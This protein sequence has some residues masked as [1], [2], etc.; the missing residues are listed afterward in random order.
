M[1]LLWEETNRGLNNAWCGLV[2]VL[3]R[4]QKRPPRQQF[5]KLLA[6]RKWDVSLILCSN[7]YYILTSYL[8]H[9]PIVY[10]AS[11]TLSMRMKYFA[12]CIIIE[13]PLDV[14]SI[15]GF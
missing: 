14:I 7:F 10:S 8:S 6:I 15:D 5:R 1:C 3:L 13:Y 11:K 2:C 9:Y 12:I 4:D